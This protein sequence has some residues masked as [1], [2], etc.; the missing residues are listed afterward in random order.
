MS[1][2]AWVIE[3]NDNSSSHFFVRPQLQRLGLEFQSQRLRQCPP[4]STAPLPASLV[5]VRYLTPAWRRLVEARRDQVERLVY[6]MDDDLFDLRAHAG[7]PLRYRW[8]LFNLAWRHRR[9]LRDM[10][11]ELWVSTDWLAQK[12]AAWQPEVVQPGSPY[13]E[14]P[15]VKT[16]FY[17]GSASHSAEI[18]W[19]YPV[20]ESVLARDPQLCFEIIGDQ[21]VRAIFAGLPRV[22]VVHPMR[23]PAYRAFISRSGRTIGL[24]PLLDQ[25]FNRSR[26]PTKF[27]DITQAGAAGIYADHAVYR[28]R[29]E[30]R[31]NGLL[32]PMQVEAWADAILQL[33]NDEAL[34]QS[35]LQQ[36]RAAL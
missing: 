13:A 2:A 23:W 18:R 16:V 1:E 28:G 4:A 24:A 26:A 8:K 11:A 36:A 7:L 25:A 30:H 34:R 12:Y 17:H 35:L 32:V 19:L 6:F 29:V 22:H 5:F 3:E 10:G 21:K 15:P 20:I 14:V 27:F 9:W 31:H 33:S